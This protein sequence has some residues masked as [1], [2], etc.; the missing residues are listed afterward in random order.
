LKVAGVVLAG[1][2]SSRMGREKA[3]LVRGNET[4]CHRAGRVL[5][6]AGV[7]RV[8]VSGPRGIP[9][10]IP[11]KGPLGGIH[12]ALWA[13]GEFYDGVLF[14]PCDLPLAEPEM[15]LPLLRISRP[16]PLVAHPGVMEP[17]CALVPPGFREKAGNAIAKGHL[18]VGRLWRDCDA[19]MIRMRPHQGF[20]DW[21]TPMDLE[22]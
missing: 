16:A 20:S 7:D 19:V 14:V 18:A 11:G 4:L 2:A 1:G 22:A 17:L 5:A 6:G 13:L 21:D 12:G 3:L 15:L 9:D 10:L 8:F